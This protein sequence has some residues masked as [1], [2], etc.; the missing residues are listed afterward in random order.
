MEG[1]TSNF[2]STASRLDENDILMKRHL[3]LRFVACLI[4]GIIVAASLGNQVEAQLCQLKHY[5]GTNLS[6]NS[7]SVC[8]PT[9]TK[10]FRVE[11]DCNPQVVGVPCVNGFGS[12]PYR[13]TTTL[14]RNGLAIAT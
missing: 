8:P 10:N 12:N 9:G 11:F 1:S 5:V 7:F 3:Q 4:L 14:Y 2:R 6:M 13:F